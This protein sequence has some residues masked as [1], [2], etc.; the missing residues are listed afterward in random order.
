MPLCVCVCV[1]VFHNKITVGMCEQFLLS[2]TELKT[3][4]HNSSYVYIYIY[5]WFVYSNRGVR[6]RSLEIFFSS[7]FLQILGNVSRWC[8][9][10]KSG[11]SLCFYCW[12]NSKTPLISAG[13]HLGDENDP[14]MG[15]VVILLPSAKK[16]IDCC[17]RNI[18]S[19]SV[20]IKM[21]FPI[22]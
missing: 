4:M 21:N 15:R 6:I 7:F 20:S 11:T 17:E 1:C 8:C 9:K 22:F 14:F 10:T 13:F 3:R 16:I 19:S 5:I 2:I 12:K 18:L